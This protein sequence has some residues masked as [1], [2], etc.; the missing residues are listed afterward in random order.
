MTMEEEARIA[1][2]AE[3]E[4][5]AIEQERKK[6]EKERKKEEAKNKEEAKKKE[7][8]REAKR[9]AREKE[10]LEKIQSREAEKEKLLS[11]P[12]KQTNNTANKTPSNNMEA[13]TPKEKVRSMIYSTPTKLTNL[14]PPSQTPTNNT[15]EA[16]PSSYEMTPHHLELSPQP[17]E[18]ED[19]YNIDDICSEDG[20]DDEEA[21]RKEIAKWADGIFHKKKAQPPVYYWLESD[22][23]DIDLSV[24]WGW[25]ISC[26]SPFLLGF[27]FLYYCWESHLRYC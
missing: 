15:Q 1:R 8:L 21:P 2:T 10:E 25:S 16:G 12:T 14:Y 20:T 19:N 24:L 23:E 26:S 5:K 13:E 9:I 7:E 22:W 3:K 18:N 6:R 17:L 11:T 4:K 27:L